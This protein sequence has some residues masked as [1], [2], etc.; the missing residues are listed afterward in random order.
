M[1]EQRSFRNTLTRGTFARQRSSRKKNRD[2]QFDKQF[3]W[4]TLK[5]VELELA[6][7]R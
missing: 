2:S 6:P 5:C 4:T 3:S 1:W 7:V